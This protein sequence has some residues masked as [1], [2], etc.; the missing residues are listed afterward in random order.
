[1]LLT[2]QIN[3][4]EN[5]SQHTVKA[6]SKNLNIAIAKA[7]DADYLSEKGIKSSQE[8]VFCRNLILTRYVNS[9]LVYGESLYQDNINESA[10]LNSCNYVAYG[11]KVPERIHSVAKSY[12]EAVLKYFNK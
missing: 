12:L 3:K 9:P 5:L 6:L 2:K 1:M 7:N 10:W 8:G 11:Y 4:S